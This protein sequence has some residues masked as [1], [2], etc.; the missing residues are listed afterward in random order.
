MDELSKIDRIKLLKENQAKMAI[1]GGQFMERGK[2]DY[3]GG[4]PALTGTLFF[5]DAHTPAARAAIC[6]CFEQ[7]EAI[8][9]NG[10]LKLI[11]FS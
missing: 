4:M 10:D 7:Y 9:V 6:A 8:A 5:D 11:Q 1:P 2:K 3:V